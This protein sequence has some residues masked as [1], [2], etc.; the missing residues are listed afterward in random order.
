M[1]KKIT[2]LFVPR[3]SLKVGDYVDYTPDTAS[4]YSLP[5][6]VSGYTSNQT[7]SQD[8]NL[9]WR[10]LSID[11]D[12][13]VELIGSI[14]SSKTITFQ[15]ALGYN[16]GVYILNDICAKLY[17]NKSLETIARSINLDDVEKKMNATGINA[18]NSYNNGLLT[19][20]STTTCSSGFRYYPDIYRYENGSGINT[21]ST[22]E[23]GIGKSDSYYNE[24][25][26]NT[27][28]NV[29]ILVGTQTYYH[30]NPLNNYLNDEIVYELLYG[31]SPYFLASRTVNCYSYD[32]Y[33]N[34]MYIQE[35][36]ISGSHMLRSNASKMG[37]I[38]VLDQ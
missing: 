18:K 6:T 24:P 17:S 26:T 37:L 25:T 32:I 22:K 33:Y 8:T 11:S 1:E 31:S 7:I 3:S 5:S 34:L 38:D 2:G 13:T 12:G 16:N 36:S 23:E 10:I 35:N 30:L 27:Y 15:G 28:S 14:P 4:T 9:T 29:N 20:G 19:Y 21:T